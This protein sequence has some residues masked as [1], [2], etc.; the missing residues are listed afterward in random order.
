[1]I[2]LPIRAMTL[3]ELKSRFRR[4]R[5][6]VQ[7]PRVGELRVGLTMPS[8]TIYRSTDRSTIYDRFTQL[9]QRFP[10]RFFEPR[11]RSFLLRSN[12]DY[13][14]RRIAAKA[15]VALPDPCLTPPVD[16]ASELDVIFLVDLPPITPVL[17]AHCSA[18]ERWPYTDP[19]AERPDDCG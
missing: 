16:Y 15:R 6:P 14:V 18:A 8:W 5:L 7:P 4:S 9:G 2:G 13:I 10:L 12:A 17:G 3:A 1:V 19:R 11:N